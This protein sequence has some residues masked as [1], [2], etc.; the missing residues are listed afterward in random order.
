M[1]IIMNHLFYKNQRSILLIALF[2][3]LA[4]YSSELFEANQISKCIFTLVL[5]VAA[6]IVIIRNKDF[7]FRD[8]MSLDIIDPANKGDSTH[9]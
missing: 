4:N 8:K 3:I 7:F 9:E 6:V 5:T 2:H 1:A